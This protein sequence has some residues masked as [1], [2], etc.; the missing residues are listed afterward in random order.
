MATCASTS[1][2]LHVACSTSRAATYNRDNLQM[3]KSVRMHGRNKTRGEGR[4]RGERRE[5]K[6]KEKGGRGERGEGRG[7][8]MD[9]RKH[10]NKQ[11][12]GRRPPKRACH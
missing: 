11:I 2:L 1:L 3:N 10:T 12:D 6:G 8:R 5:E 4:E 9:E 7:E